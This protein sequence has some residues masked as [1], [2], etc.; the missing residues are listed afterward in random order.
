MK[1]KAQN[2]FPSINYATIG[3]VHKCILCTIHLN[4]EIDTTM[5]DLIVCMF[6]KHA[7]HTSKRKSNINL[8]DENNFFNNEWK[9]ILSSNLK[10][11]PQTKLKLCIQYGV[12]GCG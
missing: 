2:I 4:I 9:G 3:M 7:W 5:N 11:F 1:N 10:I 12:W 6:K 8:W